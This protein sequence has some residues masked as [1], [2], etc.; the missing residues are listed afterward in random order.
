MIRMRRGGCVCTVHVHVNPWLLTKS[1]KQREVKKMERGENVGERER[2]RERERE[3][4]RER[5]KCRLYTNRQRGKI[6]EQ[7]V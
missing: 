6:R 4:G 5:E 3:G 2:E 1:E 7:H